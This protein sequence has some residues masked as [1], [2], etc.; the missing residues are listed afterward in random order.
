[1]K[2]AFALAAV[3]ALAVS[4]CTTP[5]EL[6]PPVATA[7]PADAPV[8]AIPAAPVENYT[9]GGTKLAVKLLGA[10][11]EVSVDGAAA[12]TLPVLGDAGD[13]YTNGRQTLF[14]KQGKVSWAIG[15]MAAQD[16]VATP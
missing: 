5:E 12:V 4:A 2:L 6:A 16:C 8:A 10:T 11:A 9:C 15:R 13:T 14:I 1:M 7:A 3:A